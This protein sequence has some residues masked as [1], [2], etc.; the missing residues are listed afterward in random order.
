MTGLGLPNGQSFIT[1]LRKALF[2]ESK[3]ASDRHPKQLRAFTQ[4]IARWVRGHLSWSVHRGWSCDQH[5]WFS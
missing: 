4:P 1:A 2:A 5:P 3:G